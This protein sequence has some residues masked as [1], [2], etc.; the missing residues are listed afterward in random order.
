MRDIVFPKGNE[1]EFIKR[2]QLLGYTELWFVYTDA[3]KFFTPKPAVASEKPATKITNAL[4]TATQ[5]QSTYP[6]VSAANPENIRGLLDNISPTVI[7]G[8]ESYAHKDRLHQRASGIN[9]ILCKIAHD[10]ETA[11]GFSTSMLL[12]ATPP[13]RA[14]LMGRISQNI[15]LVR[16][17]K[18]RVMIAS[19]TS[20]PQLMRSPH[21]LASL[22]VVL[23]MHPAEAKNALQ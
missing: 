5:R 20:D 9:Q 16:K 13:V 18:N 3:K 10:H 14:Q 15:R 1:E 23:G 19:F 21:D 7:Y 12:T 11:I 17:Y 22:F 2:A 6:R 4:I 8:I